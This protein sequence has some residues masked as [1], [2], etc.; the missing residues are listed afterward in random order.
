MA[1]STQCE[2]ILH[3]LRQGKL[4][5]ADF[6]ARECINCGYGYGLNIA[7]YSS[8][9]ADLRRKGYTIEARRI[10]PGFYEYT[11]T[12]EPEPPRLLGV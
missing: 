12:G 6:M 10:S 8:R 5:T 4:T 9:I 3:A 2:R 1:N 11:L 7:K